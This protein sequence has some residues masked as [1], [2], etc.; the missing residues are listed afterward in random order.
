VLVNC[1]LVTGFFYPAKLPCR[2]DPLDPGATL[3]SF[4][5]CHHAPVEQVDTW[6]VLRRVS[7][8]S[9]VR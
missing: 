8:L 4:I 6:W 5:A 1:Q 9:T 7:N 3:N 2:A